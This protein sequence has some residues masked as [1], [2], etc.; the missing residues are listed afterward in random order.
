[1]RCAMR[2]MKDSGIEWVG[3]IPDD[4]GAKP[5]YFYFGEGKNKNWA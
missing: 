2:K 1:M 4:W 5:I 3:Q